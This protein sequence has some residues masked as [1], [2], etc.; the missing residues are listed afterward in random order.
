MSPD[1]LETVLLENP[2][3]PHRLTLSSGDTLIV[4]NARSCLITGI[5]MRIFDMIGDD[6]LIARSSR[7]VSVPNIVLVEL[8]RP[9]ENGETKRG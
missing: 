6:R 1:E 9:H 5:G 8:L 3:D 7:F 4:P 2:N